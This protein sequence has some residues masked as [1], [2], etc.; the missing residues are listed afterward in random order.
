MSLEEYLL[1]HGFSIPYETIRRYP[2]TV[3]HRMLLHDEVHFM[4]ADRGA[5]IIISNQRE[6]LQIKSTGITGFSSNPTSRIYFSFGIDS[7]FIE[8]ND[9][10]Y[11]ILIEGE[12]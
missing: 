11:D 5:E 10:V 7:K 4:L 1:V 9:F 3:P 8:I 12:K 6:D 2:D